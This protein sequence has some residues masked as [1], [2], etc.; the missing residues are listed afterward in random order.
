MK[1]RYSSY[2]IPYGL[3]AGDTDS[4]G[5][6][7]SA[8]VAAITGSYDVRKDANLDGSVD[9]FDVLHAGGAGRPRGPGAL[10]SRLP[11]LGSGFPGLEERLPGWETRFC[12]HGNGPR[13]H[14]RRCAR[15][16]GHFR[17]LGRGLRGVEGRFP[18]LGSGF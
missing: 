18:W 7:D 17:G 12:S 4:D 2:G 15:W 13:G 10:G 3:P 8:D 6:F 11:G 1:V 5:D 14:G 16:D 9:F